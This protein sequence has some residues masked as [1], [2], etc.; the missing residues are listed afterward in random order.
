MKKIL[1]STITLVCFS[2]SLI[3]FQISCDDEAEASVKSETLNRFLYVMYDDKTTGAFSFWTANNDGT[4]RK[5][6]SI[7][8][9]AELF[10][11]Y[12]GARLTPNGQTLI[13][14]TENVTG[15]KFIYSVSTD[16]S[17][18]KKLFDGP[19]AADSKPLVDIL[20]T[21]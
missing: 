16:G 17:N 15:D 7:T 2:L 6:I 12:G 1:Y 4:D 14:T 20:Q 3:L 19:L 11:S 9:P 5:E 21:Y 8:L 10:L 13:F 18:L